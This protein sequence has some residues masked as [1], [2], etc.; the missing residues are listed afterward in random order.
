[1][2]AKLIW[3]TNAGNTSLNSAEIIAA[4]D[5]VGIETE[6]RETNSLE[7]LDAALEESTETIVIA[8]GDGSVRH[9]VKRLQ[10]RNATLLILPMG[11]ANNMAGALGIRQPPL[12][13]IASLKDHIVQPVDL[14]HIRHG[15]YEDIF[16]EG[17]GVGL[18]AQTMHGYGEDNGKSVLRALTAVVG[19]LT[20]PPV[21]NAQLFIDDERL[22]T[23]LSMLEVLNTPAIGPRLNLAPNADPTDGWLEVMTIEP[24]AGVGFLNYAVNVLGG[25][26]E[27]LQNVTV[28]RAKRVRLE[29][30]GGALHADGD[31]LEA[32]AG[33]VEFWLEA[34]AFNVLLPAPPE[35]IALAETDA[36]VRPLNPATVAAAPRGVGVHEA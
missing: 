29:F 31:S 30:D 32:N 34:G 36:D 17:A 28:R 5:D 11:T 26:L 33:M 25:G 24:A 6:L 20:A 1:V 23:E 8:G 15:E 12:E 13:L 10:G 19:T 16:L 21:L 35:T 7:D 3:N 4:L 27:A 2:R 18:F 22:T 14:G 9:A